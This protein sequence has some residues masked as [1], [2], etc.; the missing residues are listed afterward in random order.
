MNSNNEFI[1]CDDKFFAIGLAEVIPSGLAHGTFAFFDNEYILK[2]GVKNS[3]HATSSQSIIF[4][5]NDLDYYALQI[6]ARDIGLLLINKKAKLSDILTS[7]LLFEKKECYKA[8]LSLS[9]CE[10]Q[11]MECLMQGNS[12]DE[13]AEKLKKNGKTI[14]SHRNAIIK[15][16]ELQN[17]NALYRLQ[18]WFSLFK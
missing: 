7:I 2:H 4:I 16:L 10:L 9:Q 5:D 1:F 3:I 17:R 11:V 15:K 8:R 6:L 18:R 14:Y 13:T 12:V